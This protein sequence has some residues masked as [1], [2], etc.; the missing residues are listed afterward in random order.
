MGQNSQGTVHSLL[1][2][3]LDICQWPSS[4]V[5]PETV[6]PRQKLTGG[7]QLSGGQ[8][9]VSQ[10]FVRQGSRKIGISNHYFRFWPE[11]LLKGALK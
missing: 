10:S 3:D 2:S 4:Q 9:G 5:S 6:D 8:F 1:M 11:K 7:C